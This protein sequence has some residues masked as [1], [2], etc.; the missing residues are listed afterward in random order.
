MSKY[1]KIITISIIT[2][3]V[4]I[5]GTNM[6]FSA[7]ELIN[8]VGKEDTSYKYSLEKIQMMNNRQVSVTTIK[9]TSQTWQD[10]EWESTIQIVFP[11]T[12]YTPGTAILMNTGGNPNNNNTALAAYFATSI[13]T[14]IITIYNVPNQPLFDKSED[15]LI[16]YTLTKAYKSK[17]Y[18]SWPLLLPMVKTVVRAMDT[19][20]AYTRENFDTAISQFVVTGASKRGWTTWLTAATGD[21]RVIGIA[22]MVFDFLNFEKQ[23]DKQKSDYGEFS[24]QI[25]DY[26]D[27]DLQNIIK[28]SEGK[29][30]SEIIDPFNYNN[31][32]TLPKLIINGTNDQYWTIDSAGLYF[33]ELKGD[34]N[35]IYYIPNGKHNIGL[36]TGETLSQS[37]ATTAAPI[38]SVLKNFVYKCAGL[39]SMPNIKSEWSE[40]GK[41]AKCKIIV[42]PSIISDVLVYESEAPSKDFRNIKWSSKRVT[43]RISDGVM[44]ETKLPSVDFKAVYCEVKIISKATN[45]TY[46]LFTIP[47][48]F[49]AK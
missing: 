41:T 26:T 3:F 31:K 21:P 30:L 43:N 27:A 10:I 6:A 46:S 34:N 25:K 40:E 48:V 24:D 49:E 22:P 44:V 36:F 45:S 29:Q 28:K 14:P 19:V 35:Y 11:A 15:A 47:Q 33:N 13:G 2:I 17:D 42:D 16:A 5:L 39:A 12:N 23:L 9:M 38:I 37:V 18:S 8:Y 7:D 4:A 1:Y 32:L 20:E